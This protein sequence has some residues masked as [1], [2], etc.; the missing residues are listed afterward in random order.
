MKTISERF[1]TIEK[2]LHRRCLLITCGLVVIVFVAGKLFG[3]SGTAAIAIFIGA[4]P[5]YLLI[6]H[7]AG[8]GRVQNR[9]MAI[10]K[11]ACASLDR[12][13]RRESGERFKTLY[14]RKGMTIRE[15]EDSISAGM[16]KVWN[17]VW[18]SIAFKNG[19]SVAYNAN[20]GNS[21]SV[22]ATHDFG[23][24][25]Q[26]AATESADAIHHYHNHPT[27]DNFT[28]PSTPDYRVMSQLRN[29]FRPIPLRSFIV[30]WNHVL[31]YRLLEYQDPTVSPKIVY[32]QDSW[33]STLVKHL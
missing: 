5:A 7:W 22:G 9:L 26:R 19:V 13:P 18:V 20:I 24:F 10:R 32:S 2:R 6:G 28:L 23:I 4:L 1:L 14:L 30:Y 11:C 17:E 15:A 8:L 31:E 12:F 27:R 16:H 33:P 29:F 25:R 21:Y 3:G